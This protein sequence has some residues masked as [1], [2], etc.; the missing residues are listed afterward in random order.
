MAA[1]ISDA[2]IVTH[3]NLYSVFFSGLS[4]TE[5]VLLIPY[6]AQAILANQM[7]KLVHS[8]FLFKKL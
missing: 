4:D 1:P 8:N 3:R 7:Y 2:N 5:F 6:H